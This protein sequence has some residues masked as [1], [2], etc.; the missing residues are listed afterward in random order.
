MRSLNLLTR[1]K[2]K[3]GF[4]LFF[5][6]HAYL[7]SLLFCVFLYLFFSLGRFRDINSKVKI[8]NIDPNPLAKISYKS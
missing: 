5:Y 7:Y 3:A 4:P 8:A 1:Y 2:F 6:Y